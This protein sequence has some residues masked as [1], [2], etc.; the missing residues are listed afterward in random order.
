MKRLDPSILEELYAH[1]A[2]Y[3]SGQKLAHRLGL[4]RAAV[5]KQVEALRA[6]GYDIEAS[7]RRGYRLRGVP[8][9]LLPEEV[10]RAL[11]RSGP[12]TIRWRVVYR[13]QVGSTN[14]VAKELA[15]QGAPEGTV[16]LAEE[17][18][19]GRGRLGRDW[20]SPPGVGVWTTLL[21]RP[22]LPPLACAPITLVTAVA[23]ADAIEHATGLK[24]GIKWPNDL[25]L[26]GRKVCGVLTELA[27]EM[28]RL[29]YLV[30]GIGLNVNQTSV[31]LGPDLER[32][33]TSLRLESGAPVHRVSLLAQLLVDFDRAYA[34]FL[35]GGFPPLR[36]HWRKRSITLGSQV[37][38]LGPAGIVE[39]V[40]VD[41]DVEGGLVVETAGGSRQ[42]VRSGEV[43]TARRAGG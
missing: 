37:R 42:I 15:V 22:S 5:W 34:S 14:E 4:T 21:L 12:T 25:L 24:V 7:P 38:A 27:A 11:G 35:R 36:E 20:S 16:V 39:G 41:V 10:A 32:R 3:V 28:E 17:Q 30:V 9:L 40:A 13:R 23:V 31:E 8:D 29:S 19:A 18:L 1:P 6:Q 2:G 43:T 26:G 33:A